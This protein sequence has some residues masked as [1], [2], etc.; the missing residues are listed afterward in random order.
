[1]ELVRLYISCTESR[2]CLGITA[3]GW[4]V[5]Q[6]KESSYWCYLFSLLFFPLALLIL[7][8][9][10]LYSHSFLFSPNLY[11]RGS[12]TC[13]MTSFHS[14]I[15]DLFLQPSYLCSKSSQHWSHY[16][17]ICCLLSLRHSCSYQTLFVLL[18]EKVCYP[19]TT[20]CS[21]HELFLHI[22]FTDFLMQLL[23]QFSQ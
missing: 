20:S 12:K 1:M 5:F 14:Y 21:T 18:F 7:V 2:I 13:F 23:P 15:L 10:F 11:K 6:C 8:L 22:A 17:S 4:A 19:T 9:N 3:R 16:S